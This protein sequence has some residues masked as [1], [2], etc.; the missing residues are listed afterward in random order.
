[1]KAPRIQAK[2]DL[3]WNILPKE[4]IKMAQRFPTGRIAPTAVLVLLV[5][6]AG[7]ELNSRAAIQSS[8]TQHS[9]SVQP[10]VDGK[11][12]PQAVPEQVVMRTFLLTAAIAP[13]AGTEDRLRQVAML[14]RLDLTEDDLA[15]I[16]SEL[17]TFHAN[18]AVP[19]AQ[20]A[21]V[22]ANINR[23]DISVTKQSILEADRQISV[24]TR[25]SFDRL[26]SL[27]S[28]H[29]VAELRDHLE[30]MRTRIQIIPDPNMTPQ[31]GDVQ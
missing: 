12:N 10:L 17:A 6:V 27:L 30:H 19:M 2:V 11:T 20:L 5:T 7:T 28:P 13:L 26:F 8:N 15:T 25:D 18:V 24:V 4:V 23:N 14:Q 1:M 31:H 9:G 3:R 29:G 21:V 16:R 22:R